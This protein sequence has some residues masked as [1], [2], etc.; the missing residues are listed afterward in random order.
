MVLVGEDLGVNYH[1][2]GTADLV[3]RSARNA[4]IDLQRYIRAYRQGQTTTYQVANL[5]VETDA[6]LGLLPEHAKPKAFYTISTRVVDGVADDANCRRN[7]MNPWAWQDRR[8]MICGR[9]PRRSYVYTISPF[10]RQFLVYPL[11]N[12]ETELLLVWD[13][14]KMDFADGDTVPWPPEA[15]EAVASYINWKVIRQVDKDLNRARDEYATYIAKRLALFRQERESQDADGKDEEYTGLVMPPVPGP[16][17]AAG[18]QVILFLANVT[19]LT[20]IGSD[21]LAAIVTTGL[22]TPYAVDIEIGGIIQRW[23]LTAGTTATGPGVQQ[24]NDF[25]AT[26]N[27]KIWLQLY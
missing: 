12:D 4:V 20:G 5:T 19:T 10:S 25:N 2:K 27:A 8:A 26:T 14:L 23:V 7:R 13:G 16:L 6:H 15:A 17:V 1:R 11:I 18:G 9:M 24:P 3:D 21:S 22:P